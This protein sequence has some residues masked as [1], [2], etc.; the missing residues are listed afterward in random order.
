MLCCKDNK[1]TFLCLCEPPEAAT[2]AP[3][4]RRTAGA[5]QV[6]NPLAGR[7]IASLAF[8]TSSQRHIH[9]VRN[10]ASF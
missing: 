2:P 6:S 9:H 3:H 1:T 5:V 4:L 7:E 10:R 8:Q